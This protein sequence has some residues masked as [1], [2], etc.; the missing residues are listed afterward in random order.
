M[1]TDFQNSFISGLN[2]KRA[3]KGSLK[4]PSLLKR[5]VTLPCETE[6]SGS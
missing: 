2:S 3:I 4:I 6:M 1:W 5:V